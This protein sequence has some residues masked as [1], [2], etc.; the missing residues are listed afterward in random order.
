VCFDLDARPPIP[1][2]AGGAL[3]SDA[4]ELTAADGTRL[5]AYAARAAEPTGAGMV[6]LPD[7]RGLHPFYEELALRF[8][9]HGI[10]AV[11]IDYFGRTATD[12]PRGE[13]F[14][15]AGYVAQT[16]FEGLAADVR[17]GAAYLRSPEGGAVRSLFSVGFCFGGRLSFLAA[18]LGLDLAGV[19]GFY[20]VPHGNPRQ[21]MPPPVEVANR[22]AATAAHAMRRTRGLSLRSQ[23]G[24][25]GGMELVVVVIPAGRIRCSAR[26]S[27]RNSSADW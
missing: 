15:Q 2:I 9:E 10:D 11:A 27:T 16:T 14:D 20:G 26:R 19:V 13:G 1:P 3:E 4:L 7:V 21:G 24:R 12:E 25:G 8:A 5:R 23:V 6:V 22:I 17:A 18:T